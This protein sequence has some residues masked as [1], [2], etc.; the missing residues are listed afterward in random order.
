MCKLCA[1]DIWLCIF[2]EKALWFEFKE[3]RL[4]YVKD[5]ARV[6][7]KMHTNIGVLPAH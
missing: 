2:L 3:H 6:C 4:N 1:D 5:P 7:R